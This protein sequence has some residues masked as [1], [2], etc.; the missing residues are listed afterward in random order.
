MRARLA[1]VVLFSL[2]LNSTRL[3]QTV[4]P[5]ASEASGIVRVGDDLLIVSDSDPGAYYRIRIND[6]NAHVIPID[7]KSLTRIKL[8][9]GAVALDLESIDILADG[10]VVVL[11]ERLRALVAD[12]GIVQEYDD[13]LSEL[14]ERGLEGVAV[15]PLPDGTSRV[16]VV[17]EGGYPNPGDLLEQLRPNAGPTRTAAGCRNS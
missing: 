6:P 5:D 11:S 4:V 1:L 13:P 14:A 2:T 3:G 7:P 17:W 8:S 15:R 9:A 10:R 12:G 16:A